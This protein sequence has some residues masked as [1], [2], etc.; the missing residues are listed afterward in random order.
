[1]AF[2][3]LVGQLLASLG[4]SFVAV[5]IA[6]GLFR[7]MLR[8]EEPG[9]LHL[10]IG[11]DEVRVFGI[12]IVTWIALFLMAGVLAVIVA[13]GRAIGPAAALMAGLLAIG[14]GAWLIMR[15]SLAAV[16]TFDER[17]FVIL[18]SW[19]LTKRHSLSLLGM[20]VLS[21]T[22]TALMALLVFVVIFVAMSLAVGFGAVVE[23][24][25]TAQGAQEHPGL[26]LAE[27][28]AELLLFPAFAVLLVAPWVAAYKAFRADG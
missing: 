23:G 1:V 15:F 27:G 22:V 5:M 13:T 28:L 20:A 3:P 17:R 19:R 16:A 21:A 6:T 7:L 9:W 12:L 24:L 11:A 25:F 8:P 18:D 2:N 26:V 4:E 10:R 14:F